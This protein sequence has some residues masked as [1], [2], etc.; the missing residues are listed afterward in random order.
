MADMDGLK[1]RVPKNEVMLATFEAFG[2]SPVPRAWPET[3]TAL[4]TGTVDGGDNGT[5]FIRGMTFYEPLWH[6]CLLPTPS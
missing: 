2:A 4:Q 3:P 5:L 6:R 1:I